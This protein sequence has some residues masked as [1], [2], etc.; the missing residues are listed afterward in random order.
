[1][2]VEIQAFPIPFKTDIELEMPTV[3]SILGMEARG[4]AGTPK[5]LHVIALVDPD[6][7]R[8]TQKFRLMMEGIPSN[9]GLDF[10]V[11]AIGHATIDKPKPASY[12]LFL[13]PPS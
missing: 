7:A 9:D 10:N 11:R 12:W 13:R 4:K 1:M 6:S 2:R 8:T 5:Q 3:I